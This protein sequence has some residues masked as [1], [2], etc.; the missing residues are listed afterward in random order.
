MFKRLFLSAALCFWILSSV[1]A[2]AV[3]CKDVDPRLRLLKQQVIKDILAAK[4]N[5]KDIEAIAAKM[6]DDGSWPDID[7]TDK[8]RGGWTVNDHLVRLNDMAIIY[9]TAGTKLAADQNF[10]KK[11]ITGLNFWLRNDFICPNWWYPQIGVPK[12]LAPVMLLMED[13]LTPAQM[14]AGIKILERAKIGM[15]GQN[16]VWLSGNVIY[17]SLLTNDVQ[18]IDAAVKAIQE[19]IV[20][21]EGEGIQPDYSFHQHGTQQ[22]FG[23]YGSAYAGDM[24]KWANIFQN[25]A[26][27]FEPDKIAILRNYLLQ[28][29]RWI[30]WKHK[31]DIS[32]CGRQLF[33]NAQVDKAN[34]IQRIVNK[35]PLI[36]AAFKDQYAAALEDFE[37]DNHFWKSDMTVHR[38]N[39]FYASVKMSSRRVGGAESCNEENIQGYHLGDGATYFY[40]S[41]DEYTDIFPYWDWKMIPGT[42]TF[43]DNVPL[44]V[45]PCSG[46]NIASDFVGGVSDGVN[47]IAT[48]AYNRDSLTAQKSW[49]FFEDAI[50]CVGANINSNENK[51]VRTTINQSFLHGDVLLKQNDRPEIIATGEHKLNTVHWV[52]HDKWGYYF[53]AATNIE[54]S[55]QEKEGDWHNVLKRMPPAVMKANIF[56]MWINHGTQPKAMR[57]AYYVFPAATADNIEARAGALAIT[58]NTATLQVV[59]NNTKQMAGIVFVQP[60]TANTKTFGKISASKPC[61]LMLAKKY[62]AMQ[63]SIADPAHIQTSVVLTLPGNKKCSSATAVYD[64]AM[65]QTS[66]TL[67][68]PQGPEAGK[69]LTVIIE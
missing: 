46:Y 52:L 20:I 32:A 69:T 14:A 49:F 35:M 37:G 43:H 27:Q 62:A 44:P 42:T 57:F 58:E 34:S 56:S 45:L 13:K 59:E 48:L 54:L 68:L 19:E 65:N 53:P 50:V 39:N 64:K 2:N 61:V 21:S 47:G 8:T 38:R 51:E 23:N 63:L 3:T 6:K 17:R 5:E 67:L 25:T 66:L 12:V 60:A 41:N 15:T 18:A 26:F 10:E 28:G 36:D 31:M 11:I 29:M 7:Y 22:Q 30:I 33:P 40:Q 9:K 55:N 4:E 16:K 1:L 24:L